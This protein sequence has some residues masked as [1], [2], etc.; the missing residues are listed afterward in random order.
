MAETVRDIRRRIRS[1]QSIEEITSA[2]QL[3]A[4][5][6]LKRLEGRVRAS[7]PYAEEIARLVSELAALNLPALPLMQRREVRRIGC[8]VISS[9]RGLCGAYNTNILKAVVAFCEKHPSQTVRLILIGRKGHSYF[10]RRG[11]PILSFFPSFSRDIS[12]EQIRE[13]VEQLVSW[14]LKEEYDELYLF[15]TRFVT[16]LQ[17]FPT[18]VMLLPFVPP[19]GLSPLEHI[20]EPSPQEVLS[21]LLPLS[22]HAQLFRAILEAM[23]AE[24]GARMIAMKMATE[25]GEELIDSLTL[26]CNKARQAA[27]TKDLIEVTNVKNALEVI[28]GRGRRSG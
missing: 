4:V 19:Q 20:F 14:Y 18:E 17:I 9:D 6:R 21:A 23:T 11:Y 10:K 16:A 13:M 5:S 7:R 25:N 2:M 15:Y 22:L 8:L 1:I 24:Q 3:V 26:T 27:I 12:S 28:R